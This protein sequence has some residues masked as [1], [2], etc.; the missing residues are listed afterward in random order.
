[1]KCQN[2]AKTCKLDLYE[3]SPSFK[4]IA[5]IEKKLLEKNLRGGGAESA[6][7]VLLGLTLLDMTFSFV[8]ILCDFS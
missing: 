3:N 6:P 2:F 5:F 4:F 8:F 1:M 7:P